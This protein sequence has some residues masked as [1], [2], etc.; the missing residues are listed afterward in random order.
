MSFD[1]STW[2]EVDPNAK[3]TV[4]PTKVSW[5]ALR[6]DETAHV[7]QDLGAGGIGL[8]FTYNFEFEFTTPNAECV[9]VQ[10]EAADVVKNNRAI[11]VDNNR[12]K[13]L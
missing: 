9:V 2:N 5:V 6:K 7:Y 3:I 1:F 12:C 13:D 4:T 11:F 8:S 10:W